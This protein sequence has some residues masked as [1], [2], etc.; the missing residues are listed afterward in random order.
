MMDKDCMSTCLSRLTQSSAYLTKM[1]LSIGSGERVQM[2]AGMEGQD[3][4]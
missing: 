3:Q 4:P 1:T 2:S